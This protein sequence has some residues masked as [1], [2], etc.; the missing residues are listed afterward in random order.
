[1]KKYYS[2]SG[3]IGFLLLAVGA[4]FKL[5]HFPA[6]N[7]I[8][9]VGTLVGISHFVV[10]IFNRTDG[11][12]LPCVKVIEIFLPMSMAV[13]L[14]AFIFKIMHW[15]GANIMVL[16]ACIML[17][18]SSIVMTIA[19]L[20]SNGKCNLTISK[21]VFSFIYFILLNMYFLSVVFFK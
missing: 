8:L 7:V 16:T 11:D 3:A 13:T 10:S 21:V 6:S 18:L 5:N 20:K 14:F 12:R 4:I 1:M 19:M 9:L 2:I 17:S 15:P